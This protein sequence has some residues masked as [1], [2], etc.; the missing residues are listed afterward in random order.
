MSLWAC[1]LERRETRV[2]G[3][4]LGSHPGLF[5]I[6]EWKGQLRDRY[7]FLSV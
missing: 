4:E 1:G 6:K 7:K 5:S 3:K 2:W